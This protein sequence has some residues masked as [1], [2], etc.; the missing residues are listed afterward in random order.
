MLYF[1]KILNSVIHNLGDINF[2]SHLKLH[3]ISERKFL[4]RV[5]GGGTMIVR[6]V[7][8]EGSHEH[9]ECLQDRKWWCFLLSSIL[10]FIVG[11]FSVLFIRACAAVFCR[12]A[13]EYSQTDIK[14]QLEEEKRHRQQETGS[15]REVRLRVTCSY[16]Y[17]NVRAETSCLKP[18]TG[19]EN[20]YPARPA[21]AE[22][23]WGSHCRNWKLLNS[24]LYLHGRS[25][26]CLSSPYRRL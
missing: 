8:T 22:F 18:R 19:R 12:R 3:R 23:W 24:K 26:W 1:Y 17:S 25:V 2:E 11:V 10:S 14:K 5:A 15:E 7:L 6:T 20:S 9:S 16:W 21:R 13:E 4:W